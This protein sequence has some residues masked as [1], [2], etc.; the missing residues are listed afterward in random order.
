MK[1]RWL[2][3]RMTRLI[4]RPIRPGSRGSPTRMLTE[5]SETRVLQVLLGEAWTDVPEVLVEV[6][7]PETSLT[8]PKLP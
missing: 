6:K 2:T 4:E 3:T 8:D 1:L 5:V 7:L